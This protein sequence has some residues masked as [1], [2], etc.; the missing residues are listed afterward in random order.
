MEETQVSAEANNDKTK[1]LTTSAKP[2]LDIKAL[3][4]EMAKVQAR[5]P[6]DVLTE[7]RAVLYMQDW[8][9]L[10]SEFGLPEFMRGLQEAIKRCKFF[11]V[12]AHI[13]EQIVGKGEAADNAEAR[14]A[15]EFVTTV[16]VKYIRNDENG[17][18]RLEE[19]T[20]GGAK[21]YAQ[22]VQV[23]A[24]WKIVEPMDVIYSAKKQ[25][26]PA[27]DDRTAYALRLSGGLQRLKENVDDPSNISF[28][29]RDF[30]QHFN[31]YVAAG[32]AKASMQLPAGEMMN[33]LK[34][35]VEKVSM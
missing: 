16:L 12:P 22:V 25:R 17:N 14:A 33:D 4:T 5:Y 1:A 21:P 7:E 35:L 2:S 11:P 32:E 23:G 34:K 24:G 30:F 19:R 26:P 31:G 29:Q 18:W 8:D 13:R 28:Y 3:A 20:V 9:A 27:M 6:H 10:I 15:F